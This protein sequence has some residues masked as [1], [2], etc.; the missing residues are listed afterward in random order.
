MPQISVKNVLNLIP[1]QQREEVYLNREI[2][3]WKGEMLTVDA[4]TK[5]WLYYQSGND[6]ENSDAIKVLIVPARA[7]I[8][9]E[10]PD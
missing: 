4:A 6:T 7:A 1:A 9:V 10:I 8:K 5:R 3:N 2:I